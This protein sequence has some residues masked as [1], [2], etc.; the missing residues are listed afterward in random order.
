MEFSRPSWDEYF[1]N[2]SLLTKSRSNCIKRKVGC[3]L[4][5]DNRILSL[6]YN[7]TPINTKNCYEG[8]CKRCMDQYNKKKEIGEKENSS[9][10][11]LDLCMC[12]HAEENA[13]LFVNKTDLKDST[14]YVTLIPCISCVKKILQCKIKKVVYIEDYSP[15]IDTLSK[16]ILKENNVILLKW[17][18]IEKIE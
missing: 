5:K 4:V 7:G 13:L 8:G 3:I 18:N 10:K 11:A 2:I 12:L 15:E 6:G 1:M 14:M 16:N 17:E 9:G